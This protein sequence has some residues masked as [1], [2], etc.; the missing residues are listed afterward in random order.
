MMN[1]QSKRYV[2]LTITTGDVIRFAFL[3]SHYRQPAE[4]SEKKL[5]DARKQ[6]RRLALA[7][8]PCLDPPPA[9]FVQIVADD[10]NTP[11]AIAKLHQYRGARQ[12]RKVFAGLRFLGFFEASCLIDE[13]K[14][15]P[16]GSVFAQG[17]YVQLDPGG[18]C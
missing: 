17:Q 8:E 2:D 1:D 13:L 7:C 3:M 6:L 14:T 12:G 10:L 11:G 18:G 4:M 16:P 9:E 5:D 15:Y